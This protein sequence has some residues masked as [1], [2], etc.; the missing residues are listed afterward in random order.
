[1]YRG[2]REIAYEGCGGRLSREMM[3]AGCVE[4]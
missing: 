1:M 4:W 3:E 2:C